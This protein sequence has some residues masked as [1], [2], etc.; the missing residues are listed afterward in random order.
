MTQSKEKEVV[1]D[2]H[3]QLLYLLLRYGNGFFL[4]PQLRGLCLEIGLYSSEQAVN[5]AV[6]GPGAADLDR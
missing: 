1:C 6:R 2:K 3:R 5:R 4:L